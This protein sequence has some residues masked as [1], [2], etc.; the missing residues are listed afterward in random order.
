MRML[1]AVARVAFVLVGSLTSA[2]AAPR[3]SMSDHAV[4]MAHV[5]RV[6]GGCTIGF[7]PGPFGYCLQNGYV[8]PFA[9]APYDAPAIVAQ[10]ACPPGYHLRHDGRICR[11]D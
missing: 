7:H 6:S 4:M 11:A 8:A 5:V 10:Q 1:V 2:S 9:L 3:L